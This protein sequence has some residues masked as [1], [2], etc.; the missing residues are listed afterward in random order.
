VSYIHYSMMVTEGL[1]RTHV[2]R[3]FRLPAVRHLGPPAF[4]RPKC[5]QVLDAASVCFLYSEARAEANLTESVTF[6]G[7][8]G[9]VPRARFHP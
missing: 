8:Q 3:R 9:F 7:G 2:S 4:T 5:A 1:E 6:F